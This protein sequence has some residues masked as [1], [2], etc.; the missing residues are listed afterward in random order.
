MTSTPPDP[1][2]LAQLKD[3]IEQEIAAAS[4]AVD[5]ARRIHRDNP[6]EGSGLLL[7]QAGAAMLA[8]VDELLLLALYHYGEAERMYSEATAASSAPKTS[9]CSPAESR[10]TKQRPD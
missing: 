7:M 3:R 9:P 10:S 6:T 2:A 5:T 4:G 8:C 1:I